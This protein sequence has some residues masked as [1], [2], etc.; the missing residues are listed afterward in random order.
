MLK[1]YVQ[2]FESHQVLPASY[3]ST[4]FLLSLSFVL[5]SHISRISGKF[6]KQLPKDGGHKTVPRTQYGHRRCA[7]LTLPQAEHL[8]KFVT[9]FNALPAMNRWRFFMCDVFFFGTARNIDSHIPDSNDGMFSE[10]AA[11]RANGSSEGSG[12][13]N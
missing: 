11:G 12:R 7:L 13:Y 9:S 8:F 1:P 6:G 4:C 5:P 2:C 10:M 3:A